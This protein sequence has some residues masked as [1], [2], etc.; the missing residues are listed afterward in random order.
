MI[1]RLTHLLL[2]LTCVL[3]GVLV[4]LGGIG[5][6]AAALYQVLLDVVPPAAAAAVLGAV[7]L[8]LMGLLFLLAR[9]LAAPPERG[10]EQAGGRDDAPGLTPL[11]E[12]ALPALRKNAPA[13][14]LGAFVAGAVLGVSPRAR[15]ALWK[16]ILP[17][18][19]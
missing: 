3:L 6:L 12:E 16:L 9:A 19:S 13:V 17:P 1:D 11:I 15:K 8:L 5:L 10:R 14:A 7:V 4:G 2:A 18:R